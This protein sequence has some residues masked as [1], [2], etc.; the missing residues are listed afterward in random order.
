MQTQQ[1]LFDKVYAA[2]LAQGPSFSGRECMYR[3]PNGAKCAAGLL[4]KD[5]FYKPR[6]EGRSCL[7]PEIEQALVD[8]GVGREN[9][10]LVRAIQGAHDSAAMYASRQ[11]VANLDEFREI[12]TTGMIGVA[13]RY[14]LNFST[15]A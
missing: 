2:I 14:K 11:G 5:E 8:S 3:S 10:Q 15:E 12:F 13:R 6:M 4:L 7:S 9:I 1:E